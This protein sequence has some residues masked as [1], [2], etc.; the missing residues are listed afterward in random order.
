MTKV[1]WNSAADSRLGP[2]RH[3][4][5]RVAGALMERRCPVCGGKPSAITC[6]GEVWIF[7]TADRV[8]EV[9]GIYPAFSVGPAVKEEAQAIARG[10]LD[11]FADAEFPREDQLAH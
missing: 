7:C 8:K 11:A 5:E 6:D 2:M 3:I 9:I 4:L 10:I 1:D